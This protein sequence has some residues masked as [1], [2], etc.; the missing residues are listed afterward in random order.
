MLR[1]VNSPDTEDRFVNTVRPAS[2]GTGET[3]A[4]AALV[5]M[6]AVPSKYINK[7]GGPIGLN[8]QG[9]AP[10]HLFGNI[11]LAVPCVDGD[12]TI[13]KNETKEYFITTYDAFIQY[14]LQGILGE[15]IHRDGIIYYTAGN[16]AGQG[17]F[18]LNGRM[19]NITI[20][21]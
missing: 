8:S 7:P 13:R 2:G 21:D 5:A 16:V 20:T 18:I 6:D 19:V 9:L 4:D 12:A 15:A 3:S 14:H 17:G 11:V 10:A 1:T